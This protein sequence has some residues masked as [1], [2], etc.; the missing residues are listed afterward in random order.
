[1]ASIYCRYLD[2]TT[3]ICSRTDVFSDIKVNGV[4]IGLTEEYSVNSTDE[5]EF[6]FN[7]DTLSGAF[8]YCDKLRYIRFSDNLLSI[9][10]DICYECTALE[11]VVLSSNTYQIDNYAFAGCSNLTTINLSELN[12]V[13]CID[14]YAFA[15]CSSLKYIRIPESVTYIG[16]ACFADCTAL[17]E[18][19]LGSLVDTLQEETFANCTS[20]GKITSESLIGKLTSASNGAFKNIKQSGTLYC[21]VGSDFSQWFG[22]D[23]RG[24]LDSQQWNKIE[25]TFDTNH[26]RY[27]IVCKYNGHTRIVNNLSYRYRE[28]Y[29]I[30]LNGESIGRD[31]YAE[32]GDIAEIYFPSCVVPNNIFV[33]E[34][35]DYNN[36]TSV[37]VQDGITAIS[38]GFCAHCASLEEVILPDSL[39]LIGGRGFLN[40]QKLTSITIPKNV[41]Y[42]YEECFN[43]CPQLKGIVAKP[44]V[45]PAITN[46]TFSSTYNG[47]IGWLGILYYPTGSDY[48]QWMSDDS[49]YLGQRV[50]DAIEMNPDDMPDVAI[51]PE[52]PE[53]PELPDT[54]GSIFC[55]YYNRTKKICVDTS[56]FKDI[57]VNGVSIGLTT[58]YNVGINDIVE[59]VTTYGYVYDNSFKENYRLESV[60]M[61]TG[62]KG[63]SPLT[64][65]YCFNLKAVKIPTTMKEIGQSAF[66]YTGL[67][68]IVCKAPTAP[69]IGVETFRG[70][71]ENGTLYY[72]TG[73]DYSQWLSTDRDYLGY[74]NWNSVGIDPDNPDI[75]D[76]PDTPVDP[77]NPDEPD[78]PVDPDNP[79]PDD[80]PSL[81]LEY[82][83]IK[84]P[85]GGMNTTM[86]V[87]TENVDDIQVIAPDWVDVIEKDGYYE[88]IIKPNEDGKDRTG[89]VIFIGNPKKP[90][91]VQ[92]NVII[93]QNSD[94]SEMAAS[95]SL[96]KNKITFDNTGYAENFGVLVTYTNAQEIYKPVCNADWVTITE[97]LPQ[98]GG[99]TGS[100]NVKSKR[101]GIEVTETT[102]A[103]TA[104]VTFSCMSDT[105]RVLSN[106]SFVVE[107]MGESA[108]E[109]NVIVEAFMKTGSVKY[110]GSSTGISIDSLGCGYSNFAS[111]L[112]PT[113][114]VDWIHL[115]EGVLQSGYGYD[116]I[117][118]YPISFDTNE[119]AERVG[120]V[121]FV[122]T[123]EMGDEYTDTCTITQ[124][125]KPY[126]PENPDVPED[127]DNETYSPIWKDVEYVFGGN[128]VVY[129]IYAEQYVKYINQWVKEDVLIFRSRVYA[130]PNETVVRVTVN[131]I[132]QNY[133]KENPNIFAGAVG[134]SHSMATFKLKDEYGT[135]L[136][137]YHFIND[138]SYN[139]LTLGFKTNPIV[140]YM[141]DGQ[142]LF[143]STFATERKDIR[144]GMR[145]YDGT[146]DYDNQETIINDFS[147]LIV[148]Q[149]RQKGVKTFYFGG[150]SYNI[151]PK[152][153]CKYVL[154]YVN[155][156]GGYDWFP[157][158]GRVSRRD[159]LETY[160][161]TQ[162]YN[163]T[164]A[165]FG[166]KRYLST[167]N[168]SY[169]VNT[170][171]LTQEQSNRM[172]E[173]L[174]SNTVWLHNLEEDKIMPVII[175]D[176]EIEHKYKTNSNKML[177]YQIN[178]ELSQTRERI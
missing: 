122:A 149:S 82:D 134:Y 22:E 148:P 172:W 40:C 125:A 119:G 46:T 171:W 42:I 161:V 8:A 51:P 102:T 68:T 121:T 63:I 70:V 25:Q 107:Q 71:D 168:I 142:K 146:P 11:E 103:R 65:G 139:E 154:Y 81:N 43:G 4:S 67:N 32:E 87:E 143:F 141:G 90:N 10:S 44:I 76:E 105:G 104:T 112:A 23:W 169:Q 26:K 69:K 58:E 5:V 16:I 162:N 138:W 136:H 85:Q 1:M 55:R 116:E 132:C 131:K 79:N 114:N 163:N 115:G 144:W 74:Y 156:N 36:L 15:R 64:F 49:Y 6:V 89:E 84:A 167:I 93:N 113:V 100:T 127:G 2:G 164:T 47:S 48:S 155:P 59:F 147:T 88:I 135:L 80:T 17:E 29:D 160:T 77:D 37:E 126:E 14:D 41:K 24:K 110:D 9:Y 20:L 33:Q 178:L 106:S 92:Q 96:E 73:S 57:K 165:D 174:E 108:E 166:K 39:V 130:A 60:V 133:M 18:V 129:E 53:L 170:Q 97:L 111:V 86:D 91:R 13:V 50:W 52:I 137:T 123:D 140:P 34:D 99:N 78:T 176:T 72:P 28:V 19:Y 175:T 157:I 66:L 31:G 95:I 173:L 30:K 159:R 158:T 54:V 98:Q 117:Y 152:C 7:G 150:N 21:P 128:D 62:I 101:Y 38:Y 177:S 61:C 124:L 12:S 118:R 35:E 94:N 83:K 27:C 45:A 120:V 75:P 153:Q 145:Y 151:L 56:G 3:K 109:T